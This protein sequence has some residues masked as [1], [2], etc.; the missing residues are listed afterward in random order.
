[1][2]NC[3]L[4]KIQFAKKLLIRL[5][6]LSNSKKNFLKRILNQETLKKREEKNYQKNKKNKGKSRGIQYKIQDEILFQTKFIK[7]FR[8]CSKSINQVIW[9]KN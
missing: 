8:F 3:Q 4:Y 7:F 1:M 6:V 2:S 9:C 5:H